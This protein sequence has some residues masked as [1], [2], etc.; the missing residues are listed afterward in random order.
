MVVRKAEDSRK[1]KTLAEAMFEHKLKGM[2]LSGKVP[3]PVPRNSAVT[4]LDPRGSDT[5]T[6]GIVAFSYPDRMDPCDLLCNA[7]F[8]GNCYDLGEGGL[9]LQ[10][11]WL[12]CCVW[13]S[14]TDRVTFRTAEAAFQALK[15]W[16]K[17]QEFSNLSGIEAAVLKQHYKGMEDW[18]YAGLGDNWQAMRVVLKAKF[19]QNRQMSEGLLSTEDSFLLEH[20][21]DVGRDDVW[22]DNGDGSG[23]NWLGLQLMLLREELKAARGTP[24]RAD[25]WMTFLGTLLDCATGDPNSRQAQSTWRSIVR[26]AT[27]ALR[28]K[29]ANREGWDLLRQ[30][31][32]ALPADR[33]AQQNL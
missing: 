6:V 31:F 1:T 24:P 20:T 22:S 19:L 13:G 7:G 9:S 33:G 25:D 4:F 18:T 32:C 30:S 28:T 8:L 15:F 16:D 5:E 26:S 14:L 21:S 3:L 17:A 27:E 23:M 11:P 29:L 10:V 12:G 2:C